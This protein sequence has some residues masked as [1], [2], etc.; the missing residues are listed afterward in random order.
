MNQDKERI[1]DDWSLET[2]YYEKLRLDKILH[3]IESK[4][5][6]DSNISADTVGE[7]ICCRGFVYGLD[8]EVCV[9]SH[10]EECER[11][12]QVEEELMEEREVG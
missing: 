10:T 8:D 2:M 5:R 3:I 11:E 9:T 1:D 12:L 6:F 4:A 7:Q